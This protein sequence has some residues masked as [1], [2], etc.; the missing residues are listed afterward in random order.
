MNSNCFQFQQNFCC[1][2]IVL[3]RQPGEMITLVIIC[4]ALLYSPVWAEEKS[5]R[6]LSLF[7]VVQF[8]NSECLHNTSLGLCV[9]SSQVSLCS[10]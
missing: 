5:G 8:R 2:K 4:S 10:I 7:S 9:T 1:P 6:F 3:I